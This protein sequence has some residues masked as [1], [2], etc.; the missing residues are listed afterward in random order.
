MVDQY[1][2]EAD[3]GTMNAALLVVVEGILEV[4]WGILCSEFGILEAGQDKPVQDM[5][6][7]DMADRDMMNAVQLVVVGQPLVG[8]EVRS[9]VGFEVQ[10]VVPQTAQQELDD[11]AIPTSLHKYRIFCSN[12][13]S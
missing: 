9:L 4:G 1:T 13:S 10:Q 2:A 6:V 8:V 5:A 3:R 12:T 7:Q 11:Y